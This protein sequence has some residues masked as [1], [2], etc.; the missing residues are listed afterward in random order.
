MVNG[1]DVRLS[2]VLFHAMTS[3]Y[4]RMQMSELILHLHNT[5]A[6]QHPTHA[7]QTGYRAG[8]KEAEGH[9][10]ELKIRTPS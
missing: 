10:V 6:R 5:V 9:Q 4:K 2:V 3:M 1:L 7:V 8:P